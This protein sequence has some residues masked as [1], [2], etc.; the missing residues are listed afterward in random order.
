VKLVARAPGKVNLGLFVGP[1][2][3]DGRHELVTVF[4]SVSLA[5]EVTVAPV[6]GPSDEVICPGIDGPNIV[7][8]ALAGLRAGGWDAPHVRVTIEKRI[9]VAGGM[10]GGSAD[11]AAVL[12]IAP[13]LAP[14]PSGVI[15]RVAASLGADVPSQV[16]PGAAIGTGAGEVL[17][18]FGGPLAPHAFVIV[19]QAFALST[20]DVYREFDRLALARPTG[21]LATL[22]GEVRRGG[23]TLTP[24]LLGNDLEPAAVSLRPEIADVLEA[25][26]D[27]GVTHSM[28]SGSG[29]TV[30]GLCIGPEAGAVTE[31][32]AAALADRYPG[33]TAAAPVS[34]E[35]WAPRGS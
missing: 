30:L 24:A 25:V 19:P 32:A 21:E 26:L 9:P 35:F 15:N 16:A 29:P 4:E 1:R 23:A 18:R 28:V 5:D 13:A 10:G 3:E 12:R 31:D 22:L 8:T 20:A 14:V 33:A 7:S 34:E 11:A 17:E 2:R 27:A 6:D